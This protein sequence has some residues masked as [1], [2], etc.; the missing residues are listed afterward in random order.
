MFFSHQAKTQVVMIRALKVNFDMIL[1]FFNWFI[2][3]Y[4]G[5]NVSNK[6]KNHTYLYFEMICIDNNIYQF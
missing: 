4:Y 2:F 1:Y 5:F 6:K 3:I